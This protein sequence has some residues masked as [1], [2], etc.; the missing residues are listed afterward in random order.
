MENPQAPRGLPYITLIPF[1]TAA[2]YTQCL[3]TT[4]WAG[5]TASPS[6]SLC[7][8]LFSQK[9]CQPPTTHPGLAAE[10]S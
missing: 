4:A 1:A 6:K 9:H 3:Q 7:E 10:G 2:L 8:T 5:C